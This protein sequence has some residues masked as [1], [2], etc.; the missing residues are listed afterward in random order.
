MIRI[1]T[2]IEHISWILYQA[3]PQDF[4]RKAQ[5]F[6]K[7][8]FYVIITEF[9]LTHFILVQCHIS[10]PPENVRKP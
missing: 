4:D 6:L 7:K 9:Y 1:C 5:F 3:S 2:F 10:I 8:L